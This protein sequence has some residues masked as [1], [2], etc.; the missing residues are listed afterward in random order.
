[1]HTGFRLVLKPVTLNDLERRNDLRPALSLRMLFIYLHREMD[2][3]PW[4]AGE[5]K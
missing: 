4:A 2:T 5:G 1:M 3:E